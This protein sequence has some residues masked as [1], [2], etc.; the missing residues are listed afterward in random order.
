MQSDEKVCVT[1]ASRNRDDPVFAVFSQ[2][3]LIFFKLLKKILEYYLIVG[4]LDKTPVRIQCKL[5]HL[6]S[7]FSISFFHSTLTPFQYA[8]SDRPAHHAKVACHFPNQWSLTRLSTRPCHWRPVRQTSLDKDAFDFDWEEVGDEHLDQ[9]T[10]PQR[11]QSE[12]GQGSLS[13]GLPFWQKNGQQKSYSF[14][15][16]HATA[17]NEKTHKKTHNNKSQL[18]KWSRTD[19]FKGSRSLS[20]VVC[21]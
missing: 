18:H 11:K 21:I 20:R 4:L 8:A 3:Y 6:L 2:F 9:H 14:F 1:P 10:R 15:S 16:E 19:C 12:V 5:F 7:K 17:I 13:S